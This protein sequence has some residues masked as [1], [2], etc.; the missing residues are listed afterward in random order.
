V[1]I[2]VTDQPLNPWKELANHEA[3]LKDQAGKW[4]GLATFIGT[5]RDYNEG[6]TID[7]LWLEH[8]PGMTENYLQRLAHTAHQRWEIVDTL[9]LHR[10]GQIYPADT[11]VIIGVWSA[12]RAPAFEACRYLIEE[13]KHRAPFWK[14]ETCSQGCRWVTTNTP[15]YSAP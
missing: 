9:I 5:M 12:H 14:Q 2:A 11:I 3:L 1:K 8:Y 6:E 10:V 13:L 15:P 7:A 4:G